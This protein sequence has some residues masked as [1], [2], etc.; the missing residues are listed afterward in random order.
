MGTIFNIQ[1]FSLHDGPGIRT[2]I[3]L[4]GCPLR[5]PWCSNV[6][7]Q[8]MKIQL[9]WDHEK[10]TGCKK[11]IDLNL[12]KDLHFEKSDIFANMVGERLI[13]CN[14]T[15]ENAKKYQSVCP[16]KALSYEG[17]NLDVKRIMEEVLKD[18][19][20]Y[21]E[22]GGGI[23]LSGGE[24][25]AQHNFARQILEAAKKENLHTAIETTCLG[26]QENFK[27]VIKNVDLLFCDIKHWDSKKHEKIIGVGLEQIDKNIRYASSQENLEIIARI[28]VIPNFNFS[29][30]DAKKLSE[31]IKS[32]GI[33]QV[34]LLPY[35]NYGENKYK[36]LTKVYPLEG[37]PNLHKDDKDFIK[38]KKIFA[39]SGLDVL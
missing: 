1:K 34:E 3:F 26:K 24:I 39:D 15:E 36:L 4:K 23:T 2:T 25:L 20:F 11:C 33:K 8:N 9:T 37:L 35:H 16:N 21:D 31:R 6:E 38:Y 17:Y 10:C 27:S 13:L 22:S 7:S 5:C 14:T 19:P 12:E 18:K 30:E 29:E 28:P 32:L